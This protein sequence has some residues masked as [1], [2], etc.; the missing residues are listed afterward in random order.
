MLRRK[1]QIRPFKSRL[2]V[3]GVNPQILV[4]I[5]IGY[6]ISDISI[7]NF[8]IFKLF[9]TSFMPIKIKNDFIDVLMKIDISLNENGFYN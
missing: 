7:L 4:T 5:N 1:P 2:R 8:I 3:I 6:V 9:Y